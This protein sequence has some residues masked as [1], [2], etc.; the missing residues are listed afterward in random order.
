MK[1]WL[2]RGQRC[3]VSRVIAAPAAVLYAMVTDLPRMGEWSPENLGGRWRRGSG[4][5]VGGRFKGRNKRGSRRW[6]TNVEV[7]AA[8][9]DRLFEFLVHL[10]CR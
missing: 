6:T 10:V 1:K 5:T 4:P 7:T 2:S 8:E 9:P 3:E